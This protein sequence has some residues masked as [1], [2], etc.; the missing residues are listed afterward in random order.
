MAN[1][2]VAAKTRFNSSVKP[3]RQSGEHFCVDFKTRVFQ[4]PRQRV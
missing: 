3:G 4:R 2:F 1:Y